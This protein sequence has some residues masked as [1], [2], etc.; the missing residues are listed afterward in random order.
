M[1]QT[2]KG[3]DNSETGE[4]GE[5]AAEEEG[6]YFKWDYSTRKSDFKQATETS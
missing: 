2:T 6:W 5:H 1:L 3:R 4:A